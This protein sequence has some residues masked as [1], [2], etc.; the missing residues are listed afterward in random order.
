M[1]KSKS[2]IYDEVLES[3]RDFLNVSQENC[4]S[5]KNLKIGQSVTFVLK[6]KVIEI[7]ENV[8][9]KNRPLSTRIEIESMEK[10][11]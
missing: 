3:P 6:G 7:A 10:Q 8:W 11:D 4:K 9:D 1:K 2:A 5:I